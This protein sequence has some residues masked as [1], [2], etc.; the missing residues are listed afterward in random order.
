V[1]TVAYA[2]RSM[3]RNVPLILRAADGRS[4]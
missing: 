1:P 2:V 4:G 3:H